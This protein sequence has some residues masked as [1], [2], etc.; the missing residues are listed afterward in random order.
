MKRF[1]CVKCEVTSGFVPGALYFGNE[2]RG[3]FVLWEPQR[4]DPIQVNDICGRTSER[5]RL[6]T[7]SAVKKKIYAGQASFDIILRMDD[8]TSVQ[9]TYAEGGF[10]TEGLLCSEIAVGV[11]PAGQQVPLVEVLERLYDLHA[12]PRDDDALAKAL[13]EYKLLT[14]KDRPG[15]MG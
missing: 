13:A 6:G 2:G 14:G 12:R 10:H 11:Q 9:T 4:G 15:F 7:I 5:L 1:R 3:E 8:G